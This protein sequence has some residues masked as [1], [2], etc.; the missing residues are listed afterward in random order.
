[1]SSQFIFNPTQA[2][3][4]GTSEFTY[5]QSVE[6]YDE[7]EDFDEPDIEQDSPRTAPDRKRPIISGS[8]PTDRK[9]S[10][11]VNILCNAAWLSNYETLNNI[12]ST[13]NMNLSAKDGRGCTPLHYSCSNGSLE[14]THAL[15]ERGSETNIQD[16]KGN[17]PL[18]Y[19]A[20]E[21]NLAQTAALIEHG[22]DPNIQNA[23]GENALHLASSNGYT[24]IVRF[25]LE[26]GAAIN[27]CTLEGVTALH[28]ATAGGHESVVSFLLEHG[29]Y[30]NAADEQ[31]DTCLHWAVREGKENVLRLLVEAGA[32]FN[33]SNDD[34]ETPLVLADC[35]GEES[36]AAYLSRV[37][38]NKEVLQISKVLDPAQ[39][40][41]NNA[42]QFP[43]EAKGLNFTPERLN[44]S[45]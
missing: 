16:R 2:Y 7:L 28:Y 42:L 24:E 33:I 20:V 3:S 32:D 5:E 12:M 1:M 44:V 18:I 25:L 13:E 26:H 8:V 15:L 45:T 43:F 27:Q 22:A 41:H 21:G 4:I 37:S 35:I 39:V 30:L 31:G 23:H 6:E 14:I 19:A 29:A 9:R 40:E 10:E 17:T 11:N 36:M 34:E 38:A